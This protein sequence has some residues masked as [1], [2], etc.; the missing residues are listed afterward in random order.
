MDN[1]QEKLTC[2]RI[3]DKD[4]TIDRFGCQVTLKGLMDGNSINVGIIDKP[5]NLICE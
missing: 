5:Y 1:F 3:E 2:S 4:G